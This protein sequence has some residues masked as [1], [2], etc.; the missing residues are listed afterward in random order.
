LGLLAYLIFY[1][2][3]PQDVFN[4]L[5]N[6]L[7][8]LALLSFSLHAV[9]IFIKSLR[10]NILLKEN[11]GQY[12]LTELMKFYLVSNFFNHFLPTR[13]GGDII[14]IADTRKI[15][16]GTSASIAIVFIERVSGI[17]ILIV[18]ALISS[19]IRISFVRDLPFLWLILIVGLLGIIVLY[20]L[21][22]KLPINYFLKF[23]LKYNLKYKGIKLFLVKFN[24][25]HNI[26]KGNIL[27][28]KVLLKV[29][30]W[31]FILQLNVIIHYY[32]IGLSLGVHIPFIDYFLI[33]SILLIV[34]S[35]PISVNGIGVREFVLTKFFTLY[36]FTNPAI[37]ISFSFLDMLFNLILGIIGGIIYVLRKKPINKSN[38]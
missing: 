14:R 3:N 4:K 12:K 13:F 31:G 20:I 19:I 23:N 11:N 16:K 30:F 26:I 25:F 5:A 29:L 8:L 2:T 38:S 34:L 6:T 18:F 17:F 10:W 24:S 28:N 15:Q 21:I 9:G 22:K 35:V 33:I 36:G 32:L 37:A 1:K 27:N 7:P